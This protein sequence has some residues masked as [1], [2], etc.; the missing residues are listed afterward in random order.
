MQGREAEAEILWPLPFSPTPI[1]KGFNHG[2]PSLWGSAP[3]FRAKK[4]GLEE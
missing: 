1:V 2:N 4:W 3:H